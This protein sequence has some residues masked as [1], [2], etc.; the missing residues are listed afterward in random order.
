MS[1][2]KKMTIK[3][4]S[5][6]FNL[7]KEQFK[8]IAFLRQK[9][10]DLEKAV[11]DLENEKRAKQDESE[12]DTTER[13]K[14]RKCEKTFNS[15]K[16]LKKHI[17]EVH[18]EKMKCKSCDK[19]FFKKCDLEIH[20]KT[21]HEIAEDYKCEHCD[22][23]FVLEWR[24]LKHQSNHSNIVTKKCHYFNNNLECPFEELGCMFEHAVSEMCKFD[25]KCTNNLCSYQHS[26]LG[27]KP[28]P[29]ESNKKQ[30]DAE[31]LSE[32]EECPLCNEKLPCP[33]KC[34]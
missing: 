17:T 28:H 5:E 18:V 14:C 16:F 8:E 11:K 19:I 15:K 7:L 1:G 23:T 24:L 21:E 4:L 20:I 10:S 22:K 12:N 27:K 29:E 34:T 13:Y 25:K 6:E 33:W 3:S 31:N 26:M 9:V 2:L 32:E 30:V